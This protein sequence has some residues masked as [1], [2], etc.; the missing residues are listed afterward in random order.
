M[1]RGLGLGGNG[2][3]I[4]FLAHLNQIWYVV[5]LHPK[6]GHK[7]VGGWGWWTKFCFKRILTKFGMWHPY[8][9]EMVMGVVRAEGWADG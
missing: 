7:G 9:T 3:Q 2:D 5:S 4:W 1:L 8:T 6:D